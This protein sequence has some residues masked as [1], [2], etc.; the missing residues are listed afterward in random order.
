[1]VGREIGRKVPLF[2]G[3]VPE[4]GYLEH[5]VSSKFLYARMNFYTEPVFE[6]GENGRFESLIIFFVTEFTNG[7]RLAITTEDRSDIMERSERYNS[8]ILF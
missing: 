3:K 5:S 2:T 4:Y 6:A 7:V 8:S 1:M